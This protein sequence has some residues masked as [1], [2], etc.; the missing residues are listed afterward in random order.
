MSPEKQQHLDSAVAAAALLVDMPALA[1]P[2]AITPAETS[3]SNTFVCQ[4]QQK[5]MH[6]RIFGGFLMR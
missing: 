2:L 6:G 3:L 4:P 1:D 5:N